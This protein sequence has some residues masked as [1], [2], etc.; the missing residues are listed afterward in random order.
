MQV[1][2]VIH[3]INIYPFLTFVYNEIKY[4]DHCFGLGEKKG[5][6]LLSFL[7][8]PKKIISGYNILSHPGRQLKKGRYRGY[9]HLSSLCSE[10][11]EF[12]EQKES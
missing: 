10:K 2:L 3:S 1:I 4:Y 9:Y 11:P 5:V 8:S 7:L 6:H 12:V